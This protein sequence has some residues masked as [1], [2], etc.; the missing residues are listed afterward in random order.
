[1][2][3]APFSFL[4]GEAV[5][6]SP[7]FSALATQLG[8]HLDAMTDADLQGW[9]EERSRHLAPFRSFVISNEEPLRKIAAS[10]NELKWMLRYI[11]FVVGKERL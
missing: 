9:I 3:G 11:D 10:T 1:M 2:V 7:A 8:A 5:K 6:K 4:V